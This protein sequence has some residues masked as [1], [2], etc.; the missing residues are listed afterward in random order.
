MSHCIL[1]VFYIYFGKPPAQLFLN[2]A[3]ASRLNC[4]VLIS[5]ENATVRETYGRAISNIKFDRLS[6]YQISSQAFALNY[7]HYVSI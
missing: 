1:P 3:V 5:E 6:T 7:T 4:V 2:I